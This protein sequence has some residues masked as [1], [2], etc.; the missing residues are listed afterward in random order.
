V[1]AQVVPGLPIVA[2]VRP[3]PEPAV[4]A[5]IAV[6]VAE[7]WPRPLPDDGGSRRRG[8]VWRFSGRWWAKP[9]AARRDRPWATR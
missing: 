4:L 5:A 3:E 2:A 1:T 7:A 9:T 8:S 6:A